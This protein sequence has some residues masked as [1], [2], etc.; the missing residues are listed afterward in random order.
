MSYWG[1][2]EDAAESVNIYEGASTFLDSYKKY[3]IWVGDL[4][5]LHWFLSEV[6]NGGLMQFF[7]SPTGILAPEVA[8]AFRRMNLIES[9]IL[10]ERAMECLGKEYPRDQAVRSPIL[11]GKAQI[12][13]TLEKELYRLG[14]DDFGKIYDAMDVYAEESARFLEDLWISQA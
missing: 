11:S 2:I 6:S 10:V 1:Y 7:D 14:G 5:S 13:E 3:P 8:A 4:V 12:F 9:A